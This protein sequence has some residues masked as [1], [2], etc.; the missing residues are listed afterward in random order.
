MNFELWSLNERLKSPQAVYCHL[1]LK[2]ITQPLQ[3]S[4]DV[5]AVFWWIRF[6]SH[7]ISLCRAKYCQEQFSY[8]LIALRTADVNLIRNNTGNASRLI[9]RGCVIIF[10]LK[11]CFYVNSI[12]WL[13][14]HGKKFLNFEFLV[15]IATFFPENMRFLKY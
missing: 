11:S 7:Q 13:F 14:I 12:P 15:L 9:W 10:E 5:F 1:G 2:I 6:F 8:L 4:L 3:I